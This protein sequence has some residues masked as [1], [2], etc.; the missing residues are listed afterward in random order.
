[1]K[2]IVAAAVLSAAVAA[3]ASAQT[4]TSPAKPAPKSAAKPAATS[5]DMAFA[6]E[7]AIGGMAEV[8]LGN[9]AKQKASSSDVKQFGDRMV[10]DHGKGGEELKQWA[11]SK[12]ITLPAELDAK[13]KALR[14]RLAKLPTDA[15]D[16]QY[17]NEMVMDH[18]HDV[19]AFKREASSGKDAD[20]KAWAARTLPTLEEHLKMAKDAAMKV[21]ASTGGA[22]KS[23]EPKGR[24]GR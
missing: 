10:T 18:Q 12:N 2:L 21:G 4:K 6:R 9:L 11:Q 1:M 17:M 13:H 14:D 24:G 20:L 23:S 5:P 7:A 19:M 15:F 8:E 3:P 16:R 22:K